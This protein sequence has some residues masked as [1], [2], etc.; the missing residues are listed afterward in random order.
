MLRLAAARVCAD[1]KNPPGEP[2]CGTVHS[3]FS[4]ALNLAA[5]DELYTLL[6]CEKPLHP[7][8]AVLG[9]PVSFERYGIAR[10][11]PITLCDG[12]LAVGDILEIDIRAAKEENLFI[13]S[14]IRHAAPGGYAARMDA[15]AQCVCRFGNAPESLAPLMGMAAP[16]GAAVPGLPANRWCGFLLPRVARL[17]G[18]IRDGRLDGWRAVGKSLAGCGPGLT[19]SSDDML[20]GFI[21][22]MHVAALHRPEWLAPCRELAGGAV[23][24]TGDISAACLK[25]AGKGLFSDDVLA[26]AESLFAGGSPA[27]IAQA[28]QRVAAFGSTSGLDI[29]TGVWFGL[30]S[31]FPI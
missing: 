7:H 17:Q 2:L 24:A 20:V 28:A 9:Q 13:H 11:T 15:L 6:S 10:G 1:F 27:G 25:N 26:L 29:L 12:V 5:G 14:R 8:S 16:R 4:S 22:V 30:Q 23:G 31:F 3:S 19:P 21:A 18:G